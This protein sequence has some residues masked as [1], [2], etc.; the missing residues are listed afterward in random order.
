[1]KENSNYT[2]IL[3]IFE[4]NKGCISR[5][6][7]NEAK[8][9]S[10]FLYDFVKKNNLNKVAPG[11]YVSKDF[12]PDDYFILQKRFPK[13]VFSGMSALYLHH[14]TDKIP[15]FITV[16]A[17]LGYNPSREKNKILM[18]HWIKDVDIYG[19]GI[20]KAKTIF[21]NEVFVYDRERIICDL[22]KNRDKYDG[23]TFNKAIKI[24]FKEK[25][26]QI[27][28]F[29]YAKVMNIEKKMF[30]IMEIIMNEN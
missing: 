5:K 12:I 27:K 23:E 18:V 1:M 14:L 24:Y 26:N 30:E 11:F 22:V 2:K 10:W 16:S 13:Y 28:L 29:E 4:D 15:A 6:E 3:K 8:I 25:P 9:S 20:T 21:D 19:M 17:P 7:I